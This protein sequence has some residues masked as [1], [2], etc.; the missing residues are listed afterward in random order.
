MTVPTNRRVEA[1]VRPARRRIGVPLRGAVRGQRVPPGLRL[2]PPGACSP[3]PRAS[4]ARAASLGPSLPPTRPRSAATTAKPSDDACDR[5]ADRQHPPA[6]RRV[7]RRRWRCFGALTRGFL[8]HV[9]G[10]GYQR[11]PFSPGCVRG[12][13]RRPDY[14]ASARWSSSHCSSVSRSARSPSSSPCARR[15]SSVAGARRRSIAL[16]RELAATEAEL[17]AERARATSGCAQR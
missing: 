3:Q 11:P 14:R 9:R 6:R 1:E 15:S 17:A 16:E 8:G 13:V 4:R 10:R 7:A 2:R 5:G 12:A